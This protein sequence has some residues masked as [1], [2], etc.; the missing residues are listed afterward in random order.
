MSA[1]TSIK[2]VYRGPVTALHYHL[3]S[4][5]LFAGTG[6]TIA[7]YDTASRKKVFEHH[8]SSQGTAVR[9]FASRGKAV[10][11][12]GNRFAVWLTARA[13]TSSSSSGSGVSVRVDR[14]DLALPDFPRAACFLSDS[15]CAL[16][17]T[18]NFVEVVATPGAAYETKRVLCG[19]NDSMSFLVSS[20]SIFMC[21]EDA[22]VAAG[23]MFSEVVLWS[24]TAGTILGTIRGHAGPVNM[25]FFSPESS[26]FVTASDDRTVR[27]WKQQKPSQPQKPCCDGAVMQLSCTGTFYG[28]QGRVWSCSL[29]GS[30]VVG[31]G[32]DGTV[33]VWDVSEKD[34][35]RP[36]TMNWHIGKHVWSVC[37]WATADGRHMLASGGNGGHI[38]MC[39]IEDAVSFSRGA[40][41]KVI[42]FGDSKPCLQSVAVERNSGFY[43]LKDGIVHVVEDLANGT[44]VQVAQVP[45]AANAMR[46]SPSG[47]FV[48]VGGTKGEVACLWCGTFPRLEVCGAFPDD[49]KIVEVLCA[50]NDSA[51]V[52]TCNW[53]GVARLW[54][55]SGSALSSVSAVEMPPPE[56]SGKKYQHRIVSSFDWDE[57]TGCFVVGDECG[58]IHL[59]AQDTVVSS[60]LGAHGHSRV[61][62]VVAVPSTGEVLSLG[63]DGSFCR[64]M[65]SPE[66][67]ELSLLE[68]KACWRFMTG[69]EGII[70]SSPSPSVWGTVGNSLVVQSMEDCT[71]VFTMEM[72]SQRRNSDI[73]FCRE[74]DESHV[75]ASTKRGN[76]VEVMI[77]KITGSLFRGSA[78]QHGVH[79]ME[80]NCVRYC[81]ATGSFITASRDR[82]LRVLTCDFNAGEVCTEQEIFG[83]TSTVKSF[84]L[85]TLPNGKSFLFSCGGNAELL[86]FGTE[87]NDRTGKTWF[88]PLGKF[89]GKGSDASTSPSTADSGDDEN[90]TKMSC[91]DA[92]ADEATAAG[93]KCFVAVGSSDATLY[94][95]LFDCKKEAFC[96][97]PPKKVVLNSIPL[98]IGHV[99]T[100]RAAF[101]VVGKNNGE[102]ECFGVSPLF[103]T[104]C[105]VPRVH[106]TGINSFGIVPCPEE[107][108][109]DD[110]EG[111]SCKNGNSSIGL[112]ELFGA[113]DDQAVSRVLLKVD[114]NNAPSLS[115]PKRLQRADFS[116]ITCLAVCGDGTFVTS[117][118]SQ[119]V[120]HWKY[121]EGRS[122]KEVSSPIVTDVADVM[123]IA[124]AEDARVLVVSGQGIQFIRIKN[125]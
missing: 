16:G 66:S 78:L 15:A 33:R 5:C 17:Y 10:V 104:L 93:S 46:A 23:T 91:V 31:S 123:S 6:C 60:Y 42:S 28:H 62:S 20:M 45:F 105:S 79:G 7:A 54:R 109:D 89:S 108:D 48:V 116:S 119:L 4:G 47:R 118:L 11:A 43:V 9:G 57:C 32:E 68:R 75:W 106:D 35:Y 52:L 51:L 18:H 29:S 50:P 67:K 25:T 94:L 55:A 34:P 114:S 58:G 92:F 63:K 41:E 59:C 71:H 117:G 24:A 53:K 81:K 103:E 95:A 102:Y 96:P 65:V 121:E 82:M 14:T 113:G 115:E 112:W 21:G 49:G 88:R 39:C 36:Y 64:W 40:V 2:S 107:E 85:Y 120:R 97:E 30:F 56:R 8:V 44:P 122:F 100:K 101:L 73:A 84:A 61:T 19:N 26:N 124:V 37:S 86:A 110:D 38:K 87:R 3:A 74:A 22:V 76:C 69:L 98:S 27:L 80:V 70:R 1:A 90:E 111:K 125:K 77:P 13:D 99:Q 12:F 83:H 72:A